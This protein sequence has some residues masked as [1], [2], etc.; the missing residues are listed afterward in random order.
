M[1][2]GSIVRRPPLSVGIQSAVDA[3][4]AATIVTNCPATWAEA[5]ASGT[6]CLCDPPLP[7]RDE[8]IALLHAT[9][10]IEH[11]LMVQYLYAAYS[12][13]QVPAT[14][15]RSPK[16]NLIRYL[17]LHIARE[18]MAHLATVQNLLRLL[19]GPLH[20][21]REA[22][23]FA[24]QLL[25]FRFKLEP[26]SLGSLAKY[27]IA[28][29]PRP[30]PDDGSLSDADKLKIHGEVTDKA[31][32]S[33]DG[34]CVGHVGDIYARLIHLFEDSAELKDGDFRPNT[35]AFQAQW[36][37]WGF[38][39]K[40][41][42]FD[43]VSI[44][45]EPSLVEH[46]GGSD[47]VHLRT[48]AVTALREIAEQGEGSD[49]PP[50]DLESH[51]EWFWL[52][53]RKFEELAA[54]P[55]GAPVR[56]V[57]INPNTSVDDH[58]SAPWHK[59][60]D[61]GLEAHA[62]AG[63][64][65]HARSRR[66]AQLFNLRYRKLLTQ[67]HHFLRIGDARYDPAGD[68]TA[69]GYLLIG[70]F[71]EMRR[72]RKTAD[73]LVQLPLTSPADAN[74]A[75]PPF[76][77]PYTTQIPDGE[78]ERWSQHLDTSRAT[79]TLI[80]AMLLDA[81]DQDDEF[82]LDLKEQDLQDQSMMVELAAGRPLPPQSQDFPKVVRI[83][84]EAVRGFTI[85][86]HGNFWEGLPRG[87]DAA[88]ATDGFVNAQVEGAPQLRRNP[89]GSFDAAQSPLTRRLKG[90]GVRLMPRERPPVPESRIQYI[91]AWITANCPDSVPAYPG[92]VRERNPRPEAAPPVPP[93]ANPTFVANIRPLF[94]DSDVSCMISISG[95]DL[96]NY[97]DVKTRSAAIFSQLD[98]GNMPTDGRWPQSD[99]DLFKQ[100]M[101]AG[102]P[103]S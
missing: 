77:L 55:G 41:R 92:M 17:L 72:I 40:T 27:V 82:L 13:D 53:Y 38:E 94:R 46:F 95:F 99:I 66:W 51:F 75:G 89:D 10:E 87:S 90:D 76:E 42:S 70:V 45:S 58:A 16:V 91:E 14:D 85:G 96:S 68:R 101:D 54:M 5:T 84:E 18:E 97:N 69:R 103:E 28:E 49:T 30:L 22:S 1:R 33:N 67:L 78:P 25:P 62:A 81:L 7:P 26:L 19:G 57:P 79:T 93:V 43:G 24:S 102:H 80:D 73:K 31:K 88:G 35:E 32:A 61:A 23:P 52:L 100:W 63:R 48:A 36:S 12:V 65:T 64:I 20:L 4:D 47:P 60:I 15:P 8:A 21:D 37:D 74:R 59:M 9:A 2:P 3:A 44:T 56:P 71:N 39:G 6:T 50:G 86:R 98:S 83:L 11:A 34:V 29:S